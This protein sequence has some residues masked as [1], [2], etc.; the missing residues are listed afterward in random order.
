MGGKNPRR[1][2]LSLAGSTGGTDSE[3]YREGGED[4]GEKV[5]VRWPDA[6]PDRYGLERYRRFCGIP[7]AQMTPLSSAALRALEL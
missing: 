5:D 7:I 2:P 1:N 3:G 6:S 4:I